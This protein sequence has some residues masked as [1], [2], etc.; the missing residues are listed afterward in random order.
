MFKQGCKE[1]DLE[2]AKWGPWIVEQKCDTE[3]GQRGQDGIRV[4]FKSLNL[5]IFYV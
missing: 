1:S 5:F 3:M 4:R 2:G